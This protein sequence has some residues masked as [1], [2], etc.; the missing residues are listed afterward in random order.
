M[1]NEQF[2]LPGQDPVQPGM[3]PVQPGVMAQ[4]GQPMTQL[5]QPMM[6]PS[7]QPGI[8]Q[9]PNMQGVQ[10]LPTYMSVQGQAVPTMVE[11]KDTAGLIKTIVIVILS[12]ALVTFVVLFAWKATQYN[13]VNTDVQGQITAA[14]TEAVNAAVYE[15]Q[16]ADLEKFNEEEKY[17]F[18][19][20]VGP[21]DYGELSFEYPKT[22]S[23][24]VGND[25]ANGGDYN[26]YLNPLEVNPVSNNT[27]NALRVT[28]LGKA[29]DTVVAEYQRTLEREDSGL[30]VESVTVAGTT[31]NRYTGKIPNTE[32][33]GVFVVFKIRD[34]TAILQTDAMVFV[35]DFNTLLNTVQFN[36]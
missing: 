34:K 31:A 1:N 7:M 15:T 13:V 16:Q 22:W 2:A 6:Q 11:E 3:P 36:A 17:P 30:S 10:P 4:N 9:Q 12:L 26:A 32:L 25:A 27:V 28:I 33:N 20:F 23:V 21:A 29:F 14:V 19:S 5:A 24:Y 35:D 8:Q 18:R